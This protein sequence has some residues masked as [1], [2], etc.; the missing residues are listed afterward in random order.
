M[1]NFGLIELSDEQE[2]KILSLRSDVEINNYVKELYE[3]NL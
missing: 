3:L 1:K 2:E